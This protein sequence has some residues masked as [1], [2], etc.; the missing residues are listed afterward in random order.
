MLLS[1]SGDRELE[2]C[3]SQDAARHRLGC[4]LGDNWYLPG[5]L[6]DN[7]VSA[8]GTYPR[9]GSRGTEETSGSLGRG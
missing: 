8:G 7:S 5:Y 1:C 6:G 2:A 9:E 4:Y 3:R